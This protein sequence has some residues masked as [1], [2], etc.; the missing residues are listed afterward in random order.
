MKR[1]LAI[2]FVSALLL[3]GCSDPSTKYEIKSISIDKVE[4]MSLDAGA[5]GTKVVLAV[6]YVN[7]FSKNISIE[8]LSGIVHNANGKQIARIKAPQD[9]AIMVPRKSA[10]VLLIPLDVSFNN[11]L[12]IMAS[13]MQGNMSAFKNLKLDVELDVSAGS[14]HKRFRQ[15]GIAIDDIVKQF[16]IAPDNE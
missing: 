14:W 15:L 11:P 9:S 8:N 6:D 5:L 16:E 2:A 3:A 10:D 7:D 12:S 13:L 1:F 4:G